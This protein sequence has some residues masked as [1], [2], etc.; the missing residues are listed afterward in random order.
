MVKKTPST[1]ERYEIMKKV[2]KE[3][4]AIID[5]A[6]DDLHAVISNNTKVYPTNHVITTMIRR[7]LYTACHVFVDVTE[8]EK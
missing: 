7:K 6:I 3:V 8:K 4:S 2:I 1:T 5:K